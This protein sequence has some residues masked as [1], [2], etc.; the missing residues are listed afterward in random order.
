MKIN[1]DWN[2]DRSQR[3]GSRSIM[4]WESTDLINWSNQR[5]V[6]VSPKE[7]GNTWAPEISYDETTGEYIVFWASKL[8]D[9][10]EHSGAT[11]NKMMYSKTRDFYTFTEPKVYMDY[12][13]SVIDTTMIKHDGKVYRFTKDERNNTA[14][15]PN[16]K[17]VFQEV[18]DSILDPTFDLIKEGIG[19]GSI[20]AGEG[21]TIFKSNTE[22]KWYMFIDEFGGRGYVPFETTNLQSGEW[23]MS[24]NYSLPARPR[25]GTVMPVTKSEYEALLANVPAVK[26]PST[27]QN[28]TSVTLDKE[29]L[30]LA[31][32][33]AAQLTATVTPDDAVH[34]DV[35]WSSN[36]EE[37][38]VVD[39]TGKVT[40]KK[41]GTAKIS[42]TTVDGGYMAV[43]EVIVEKQKDSTPPEGHFVINTGAEFTKDPN[44]TLSLE[45]KDDLSGVSQVRFSTD[46]KEWTEWEAY[47]TAKEFTLP[48][49]DGEK[50]VYVEFNDHAG[51]V[52][53]MYQQ[54]ITLDMTAPVI[55]FT[56]QQD[57]YPVDSAINIT[58]NVIDE[59]SG[60]ASKECSG[61]EGP[62]Y[63]FELGENKLIASATDK[64]GN[65]AQAEIQ[66]TVNVD[67][68]SLSRLT[69]SFVSKDGVAHALVAK[70]QS[71]KESLAKEN[72][73]A[74]IGQ[75]NAYENQL[76]TQSEKSLTEQEAQLLLSLANSLK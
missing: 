73:K 31:E 18:G 52:S 37:V 74:M 60:I 67:F 27:E 19:K 46:A 76:A 15:S 39:E 41:E 71:A 72:K 9:N 20:G 33:K 35:L 51:N 36:N 30:E 55:Q 62:A 75:L 44:V 64:A 8:Y 66:F 1:G 3:T 43:S 17:F 56:G 54:K 23:K 26:K 13:Y 32:G 57:T 5:M 6:E 40:A 14:S 10:D 63:S 50:T 34:Q 65:T 7:A 4:V 16:G 22:E 61:A 42:V 24:T 47:K 12:G 21:P 48:S 29:K 68:D 25:H 38:A 11:Y 59:L 58:C 53:E 49:G 28:T 45:A 69:Q 70:L 2:W